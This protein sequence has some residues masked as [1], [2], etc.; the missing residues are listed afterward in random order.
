MRGFPSQ[1]R[2]VTGGWVSPEIARW[3][4]TR[5]HRC[6]SPGTKVTERGGGVCNSVLPPQSWLYLDAGTPSSS[7][8]NSP[9]TSTSETRWFGH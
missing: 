5:F 8:S 9:L 4:Y 3:Q 2:Q 7:W 6:R 1:V